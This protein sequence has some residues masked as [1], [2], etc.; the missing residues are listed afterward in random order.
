M[1]EQA[2][3]LLTLGREH[4]DRREY[5]RAEPLLRQVLAASDRYAD[6]H[7]M[8][9]VI[10]H[11]RGDFHGAERHLERAVDLNP[12]YTEALLNL[13]V[14]YNDLGKYDAARRVY[15]SIRRDDGS[16]SALNDPFVRGKLANMHAA[17]A[18][19]YVD[20]GS[21]P[22]AIEQL[23]KAIT[24]CPGFADLQSR[25][26]TLHRD[27]DD[28]LRA[29]VH[30]EAARTANPQ[31]T[32]ARVLLGVTLLS[33]GEADL[34]VAEWRDVL[35]IDPDNRTAKMYLRMVEAQR[36]ARAS[37]APPPLE[38]APSVRPGA[39]EEPLG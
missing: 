6:V 37:K 5:D 33:L 9:A 26:G 7:N 31:Y 1:D 28:F 17:L 13:A 24:L 10:L 35:V 12:A 15:A 25:L 21:R 20:A 22:D 36:S 8:M 29:R 14:T 23:E 3:Q 38:K 27:G 11:D 19:A 30:Y 4:Y 39:G 34:A 18:Q 2:K 32:P 16:G